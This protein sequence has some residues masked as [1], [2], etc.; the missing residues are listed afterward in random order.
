MSTEL[1]GLPGLREPLPSSL[2]TF[3]DDLEQL[4]AR[5]APGVVAL[6]HGRGHGT[7]MV[8]APDGLIAEYGPD[9]LV[10]PSLP[11]GWSAPTR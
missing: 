11:A 8:L 3:S 10:P 7:G 5:A 6:E 4:V 1:R 9:Q 2:A